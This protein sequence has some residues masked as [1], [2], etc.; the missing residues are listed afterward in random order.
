MVS[1]EPKRVLW[2]LGPQIGSGKG[3]ERVLKYLPN[4]ILRDEVD[5]DHSLWV[6]AR[7]HVKTYSTTTPTLNAAEHL[8]QALEPRPSSPTLCHEKQTKCSNQL[9]SSN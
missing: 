7:R 4:H 3:L 6:V 1:Y 8:S 9:H 5:A 2:P